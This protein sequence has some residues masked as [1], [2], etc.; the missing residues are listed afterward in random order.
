MMVFGHLQHIPSTCS[1]SL[2][3]VVGV[4][5][6][7]VWFLFLHILAGTNSDLLFDEEIP[8]IDQMVLIEGMVKRIMENFHFP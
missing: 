4:G 8:V 1:G 6:Q 7:R 3:L 2:S 5:G